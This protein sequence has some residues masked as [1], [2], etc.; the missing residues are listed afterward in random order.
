MLARRASSPLGETLLALDPQGFATVLRVLG[1][2]ALV[3]ARAVTAALVSAL[4]RSSEARP[5]GVVVEQLDTARAELNANR[6][7]VAAFEPRGVALGA[8]VRD[9]QWTD[10][11]RSNLALAALNLG[12]LDA[13]PIVAQ[14]CADA[15]GAT[16]QTPT[17]DSRAAAAAREAAEVVTRAMVRA[18]GMRDAEA[19]VRDALAKGGAR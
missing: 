4:V 8:L 18:V 1:A 12:R 6:W 17:Y 5:C 13:A 16:S 11:V 19:L 9:T 15:I 2:P 3:V 14:A 7:D 10:A